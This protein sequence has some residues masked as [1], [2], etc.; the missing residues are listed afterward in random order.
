MIVITSW[1]ACGRLDGTVDGVGSSVVLPGSLRARQ[2]DRLRR[3]DGTARRNAFNVLHDQVVD[4]VLRADIGML[5]RIY[6]SEA[7]E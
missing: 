5:E 4:I 7:I 2:Q 3:C 1:R 6:A